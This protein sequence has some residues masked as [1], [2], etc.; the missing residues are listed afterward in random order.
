[1]ARKILITG[2]AGFIGSNFIH[3]WLKK[4]RTDKIINLDKLTYAGH[5]Q[6]LK[7]VEDNPRYT[8]VKG[9][10]INALVV[11]KVMQQIDWVVHFA[12]ESHVDRSILDPLSFVKTNVLGTAV[13]LDQALKQKVQRFHLV[14]TDEVFGQLRLKEPPFTEKSLLVP[15]TPYAAS[16]AGADHLALSYF[17]TYGLPVSVTNCS[18]NFG[19]YHDLE[20]LIPRFITNLLTGQKVP[21]MGVGTNIRDWLYVEDHCRAI[22]LVLHKGQVGERYCVGGEEKSNLEVTL[23]ILALL[24][25]NRDKIEYVPERLG[26]DFRYAIDSGKIKKLGFRPKETF[27]SGLAKTVDWYQTNG[28]WWKSMV[29]GRPI[30]DRIAQKGYR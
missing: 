26:H 19:P 5:R 12:A 17:Q 20:K 9:D 15:R 28:W 16:K 27:E 2:G 10:I 8:F 4:Y 6:S 25:L 1:M 18:N 13:L 29:E 22:D 7:D 23:A 14:S 11:A 30:V 24:D 3:Y 21:L